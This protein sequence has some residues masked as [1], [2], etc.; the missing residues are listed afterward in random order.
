MTPS[1]SLFA[2]AV[3]NCR[4]PPVTACVVFPPQTFPILWACLALP[5]DD[6]CAELEQER[7]NVRMARNSTYRT[8]WRTDRRRRTPG[9]L[10]KSLLSQLPYMRR[11]LPSNLPLALYRLSGR[12][13]QPTSRDRTPAHLNS[14][15]LCWAFFQLTTPALLRRPAEDGSAY[16]RTEEGRSRTLRRNIAQTMLPGRWSLLPIRRAMFFPTGLARR[17]SH[18]RA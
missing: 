3:A 1:P 9:S 12:T 6:I 14:G 4:P 13:T 15:C 18:Q 10:D 8:V 16:L 17:A 11:L 2:A 5:E 7:W